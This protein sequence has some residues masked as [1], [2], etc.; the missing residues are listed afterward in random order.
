M[1]NAFRKAIGFKLVSF[2]IILLIIIIMPIT[3][4]TL[5]TIK[6]GSDQNLQLLPSHRSAT[7]LQKI[8][9]MSTAHSIVRCCGKSL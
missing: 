7:E 8:T 1:S 2:I 5:G 4:G 9:L 6:K 3:F